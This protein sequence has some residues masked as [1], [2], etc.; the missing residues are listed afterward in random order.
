LKKAV[1]QQLYLSFAELALKMGHQFS[2]MG[3]AVNS[4]W[5]KGGFNLYASGF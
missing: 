4:K 5:G 2:D 1:K 3:T